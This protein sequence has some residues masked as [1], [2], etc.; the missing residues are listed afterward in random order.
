MGMLKEFKDFAMRGNV[1]DLAVGFIVGG[2]FQKIVT[3]LVGDIL[4]PPLG[5]LTAAVN[6]ADMFFPLVK[7]DPEK[8]VSLAKARTEGVPVIAYGAFISSVIDFLIMAI[9]VFLLVKGMNR[10]TA[11]LNA[12]KPAEPKTKECPHCCST[13]PV[14]ATRCGHCTSQLEVK[15]A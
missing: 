6:F 2:A 9:C 8:V 4:M 3:S 12:S 14:K 10:V 13:I 5:K 7:A 15:P 11:L 1:V